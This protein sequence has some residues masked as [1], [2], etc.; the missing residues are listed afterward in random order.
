[1]I[2]LLQETNRKNLPHPGFIILDSPLVTYRE[3]EEH[4]GEGVQYNLAAPE[5]PYPSALVPAG[6]LCTR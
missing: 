5:M 6:E 2:A 3:P 1:M 4:M